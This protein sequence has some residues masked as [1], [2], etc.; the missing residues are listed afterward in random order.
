MSTNEQSGRRS[1]ITRT[2]ATLLNTLGSTSTDCLENPIKENYHF[3]LAECLTSAFQQIRTNLDFQSSDHFGSID[4]LKASDTERASHIRVLHQLTEMVSANSS[5]RL[6]SGGT[7]QL[8]LTIKPTHDDPLTAEH[9]K[10]FHKQL[11][12]CSSMRIPKVNRQI[13]PS[14]S[15][16]DF[17]LSPNLTAM[18]STLDS[19]AELGSSW[20]S[21]S[22]DDD[23][24]LFRYDSLES[25]YNDLLSDS[26]SDQ[27]SPSSIT[28]MPSKSPSLSLI[29]PSCS[30]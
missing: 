2:L 20:I 23:N 21:S 25:S 1:V 19:C 24:P 11:T 3:Y 12:R 16:P 6:T 17:S 18:N 30:S 29:V 7:T 22:P 27:C 5:A 15:M 9:R 4:S 14:Q 26:E 8:P 13:T 10:R 28:F